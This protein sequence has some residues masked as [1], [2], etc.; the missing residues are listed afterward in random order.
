MMAKK[1]LNCMRLVL[2]LLCSLAANAS[3]VPD[4]HNLDNTKNAVIL[5]SSR[6]SGSNLVCGCLSAITRK[7][8][9]WLEWGYKVFAAD[10]K[11]KLQPSYNRLHLL[12]I[13]EEPLLYRLH[14]DYEKIGRIPSSSNRLIFVTRNPKELLFREWKD[15]SDFVFAEQFL[16][17]YLKM[18]EIYDKWEAQNRYLVFY[19]DLIRHQNEILLEL[20]TFMEEKPLFYEDYQM[21]REHYLNSLLD[22]YKAQHEDNFGG[23]SVQNGPQEIYYSKSVPIQPLLEIDTYLESKNPLIWE[24]YLN[25]FRSVIK[26]LP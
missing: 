7:P 20:L 9:S 3:Q 12:L 14:D 18:F 2:F 5:M 10:S 19:E 25:R 6:H 4:F 17:D 15:R 8:I 22:S 24:K 23:A 26:P 16:N 1:I 13:C 11:F 21:Y